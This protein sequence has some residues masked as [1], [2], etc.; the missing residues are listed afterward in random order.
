VTQVA[1][2]DPRLAAVAL[3][4]SPHDPL[5]HL[6]WEYRK[7][8]PL[9]RWPALLALRLGGM[10]TETLVPARV[11]GRISPRSLLLI[12][13]NEDEIV[14]RWITERLYAAAGDPK[15]MLLVPKAGHGGFVEADPER[16]P[17][18]LVDFFNV[19]LR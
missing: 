8:G 11:I 3:A 1:V 5:E 18:E 6:S 7:Y 4:S 16:Y 13:G 10:D 14:P 12:G 17:R 2:E 19:L 9:S 15:R